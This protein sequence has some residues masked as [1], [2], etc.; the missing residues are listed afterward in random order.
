[1]KTLVEEMEVSASTGNL[2]GLQKQLAQWEVEVADESITRKG[3]HLLDPLDLE[4]I[5]VSMAFHIPYSDKITIEP[6]YYLL[7]YLLT[8]AARD[9]QVAIVKCIL[10]EREWFPTPAAAR[11]AM[12]KMSFDVLEIFQSRGWDIN[13]LFR[14]NIPQPIL[15]MVLARQEKVR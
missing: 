6:T 13:Q 8:K 7:N 3:H 9:N 1:M 12:A 15:M 2:A 14:H 5:E 10:D 11:V 4:D